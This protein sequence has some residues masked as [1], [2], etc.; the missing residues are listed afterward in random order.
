MKNKKRKNL[1]KPH[2]RSFL[3]VRQPVKDGFNEA[4]KDSSKKIVCF[5]FERFIILAIKF[6]INLFK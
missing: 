2:N 4:L 5:C 6:F 1:S 3:Q